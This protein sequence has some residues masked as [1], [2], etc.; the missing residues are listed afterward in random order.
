MIPV[1]TRIWL[2]IALVISVLGSAGS[3]IDKSAAAR[4]YRLLLEKPYVPPY[5]NEESLN[6]VW[7]V[8]PEPLRSLA[9]RST[10]S[11]RR[12]MAFTRYGLTPRSD[13]ESKSLQFVVDEQGNWIPN[14]FTCH[15][16]KLMGEAMPGLPNTHY[17]LET[18]TA[19]MRLTKTRLN[20]PWNPIDLGGLLMPLG[21]SNGTTNAV[22]FGVA[23]GGHRDE[24]L[25][26]KTN[27]R[28]QAL[29]H[30]DMDAPPWWHFKKKP[31]LYIDGFAA[32][33]HRALMQ[34]ALDRS[35]GPE[36]FRE[37]EDDFRDIYAYL[38]AI[39][40]PRYPFAVDRALAER[41]RSVFERTCAECH[42][43]YG[44]SPT[45]PNRIVPWDLIGTDRA[46]LEALTTAHRQSYA[47]NWFSHFGRDEVILDPGGYLAPPLDGAWA[48]APYFHNGSVPT[49]WHVLHP[50]KR[51]VVWRRTKDGY[52]RV[53]VGLEVEIF[54]RLPAEVRTAADRRT[55]FETRRFGKSAAGH[56][57]P[58]DLDEQEKTAVLEY[59][60]PL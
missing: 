50:D 41:G 59:L 18:L 1:V 58:N 3:A 53:R 35:N 42:G 56:L 23:L 13:D 15:G 4:G 33:G 14:C 22:I 46:R 52:D 51:P 19:E 7:E 30:H 55:Y 29:I 12:K 11:E 6:H 9:E 49:L 28:P 2:G 27:L 43:T 39:E 40:T 10:P 47:R 25:N 38:E 36:K 16:G 24:Q 44:D 45:Y 21:G 20:K 48:S 26:V 31:M 37:W 17:A 5:F 32:K 57:F 8:W 54:D 60:K 34:F